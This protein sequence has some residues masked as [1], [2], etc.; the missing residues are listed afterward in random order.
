[1]TEGARLARDALRVAL[2]SDR[3]HQVRAATLDRERSRPR[4]LAFAAA[5][6]DR[7]PAENRLVERQSLG[8]HDRTIGHHLVAGREAHEVA[9]HHLVDVERAGLAVPHDGRC[10]RH[11]RRQPLE[12]ALGADFLDDPDRGVRH[13]DAQEERVTPVAVDA[14]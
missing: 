5:H 7:L 11:E 6:W 4:L 10:R 14:A 9:R 13:E 1:M 2:H 3:L 8:C 12:R